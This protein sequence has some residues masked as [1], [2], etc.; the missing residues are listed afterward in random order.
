M[1]LKA[2]ECQMAYVFN[3]CHILGEKKKQVNDFSD[4]GHFPVYEG[5][6]ER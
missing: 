4:C 5:F 6:D 2:S 3:C 1:E